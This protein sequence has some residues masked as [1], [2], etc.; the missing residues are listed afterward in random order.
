VDLKL[1]ADVRLEN[2]LGKGRRCVVHAAIFH[3]QQ[4]V[5]KAYRTSTM[6]KCRR[7]Y[8]MSLAEFEH[9]RNSIL[10]GIEAIRQYIARPITRFGSGDG[11]SDAFVQQRV[12]GI[13]LRA[14]IEKLGAVPAETLKALRSIVYEAN[15]AGIYDLD[16]CA[17]NIRVLQTAEGWQPILFDFN[18]LPQ[19]EHSRSPFTTF[20]YKIGLRKRGGR[21]RRHLENFEDWE[22]RFR[23]YRI[24]LLGLKIR[25]RHL[26]RYQFWARRAMD[27][28]PAERTLD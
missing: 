18:M 10:F 15:R 9:R 2:L 16:L 4:V 3:G 17:S 21:D 14:L 20:F 25:T 13:Y 1:P 11:Y 12:D 22:N 26:H 5:V 28:R 23:R 7:R 6:A 24:P 19:H 27:A 8:G